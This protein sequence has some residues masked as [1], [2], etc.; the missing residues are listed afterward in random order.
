MVEENDLNDHF[1][2]GDKVEDKKMFKSSWK[3]WAQ[4][5]RE[6]CKKLSLSGFSSALGINIKEKLP[7]K[8]S[9]LSSVFSE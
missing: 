9:D 5:V 8:P 6:N 1:Y 7:A 2:F 4:S 3:F